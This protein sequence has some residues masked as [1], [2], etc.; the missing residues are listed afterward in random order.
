MKE[1]TFLEKL[2]LV[3]ALLLSSIFAIGC[4]T[5]PQEDESEIRTEFC[6]G[7]YF[8]NSSTQSYDMIYC[9]VNQSTAQ[10]HVRY[11]ATGETVYGSSFMPP[12]S[13]SDDG[14]WVADGFVDNTDKGFPEGNYTMSFTVDGERYNKDKYLTWENIPNWLRRPTIYNY[15]GT[16]TADIPG[17]TSTNLTPRF[18]I[19]VYINGRTSSQLYG[20]SKG[21][22]NSGTIS[23]TMPHIA[24]YQSSE[25]YVPVLVCELCN[26]NG[27]IEQI[28]YYPGEPFK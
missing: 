27:A 11:G 2:I 13:V 14:I 7:K 25:G 16:I 15:N 12:V 28:L 6:V 10:G 17:V 26:E 21:Q 4:K 19:K 5:G 24:A 20:Q 23:Y 3:S 1:Q 18:R 8:V 9:A 22:T